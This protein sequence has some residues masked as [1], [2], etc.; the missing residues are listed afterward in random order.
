MS[1]RAEW[2]AI[3]DQI[4]GLVDGGKFYLESLRIR[5]EDSYS[6]ARNAYHATCKRNIRS[7]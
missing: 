6:I 4:Q 2:K 3:S 7:R 1:W 5:N